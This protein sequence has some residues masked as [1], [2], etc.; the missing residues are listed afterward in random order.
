M[1]EKSLAEMNSKLVVHSGW[2]VLISTMILSATIVFG[3]VSGL[4][5]QAGLGL[6][7]LW[8]ILLPV[9]WKKNWY[10]AHVMLT[11]G[12]TIVVGNWVTT[13]N[14]VWPTFQFLS[15]VLLSTFTVWLFGKKWLLEYLNQSL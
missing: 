11:T 2:L 9:L 12:P 15:L 3:G 13:G 7:L 4:A 5:A 14:V 1:E 10:M 8:A 6:G